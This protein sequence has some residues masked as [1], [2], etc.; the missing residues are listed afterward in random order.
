MD[1]QVSV[2]KQPLNP[3]FNDMQVKKLWGFLEVRSFDQ[4][5]LDV[6]L[7]VTQGQR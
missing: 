2:V 1:K 7:R 4:H 6:L 3:L 5:N